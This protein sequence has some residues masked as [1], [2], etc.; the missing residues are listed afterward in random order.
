MERF[1]WNQETGNEPTIAQLKSMLQDVYTVMKEQTDES[2]DTVADVN[3]ELFNEVSEM[4][5]FVDACQ[6]A[7]G[8]V[9][10][11]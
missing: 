8:E 9:T 11:R 10:F 4:L 2:G 6:F 5:G 3:R 1:T 7:S